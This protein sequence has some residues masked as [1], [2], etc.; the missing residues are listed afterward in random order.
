VTRAILLSLV[1]LGAASAAQARITSQVQPCQ[2][3]QD[4]TEIIQMRLLPD[5]DA[6][7]AEHAL[8][9]AIFPL[10][11]EEP[12]PAMGGWYTGKDWK[13]S[14]MP[15]PAWT[16][17]IPARTATVR[18]PGGVC[19]LVAQHRAPAGRYGVFAGW[20]RATRT[21]SAPLDEQDIQ[22]AIAAANPTDPATAAELQRL[23]EAYRQAQARLTEGDRPV[24][25]AYQDMRNRRTFWQVHAVQCEGGQ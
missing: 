18:I 19:G 11:G 1:L 25:M 9:I 17:R 8:F 6:M 20:G 23:L 7:A 16:G 21:D 2:S 10:V 3:S 5:A 15:I 12:N 4:C 22:R 24:V 14:S 13:L